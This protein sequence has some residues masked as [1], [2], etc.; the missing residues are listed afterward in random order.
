MTENPEQSSTSIQSKD[1]KLRILAESLAPLLP[2][3]LEAPLFDLFLV[4][5]KNEGLLKKTPR[6]EPKDDQTIAKHCLYTP[7]LDYFIWEANYS[8]TL[9]RGGFGSGDS[10]FLE[11]Y[12]QTSLIYPVGFSITG[13]NNDHRHKYIIPIAT[14]KASINN[15]YSTSYVLDYR[16]STESRSMYMKGIMDVARGNMPAV[17]NLRVRD[18]NFG[19]EK[20]DPYSIWAHYMDGVK[21]PAKALDIVAFASWMISKHLPWDHTNTF[22]RVLIETRSY[23]N[24]MPDDGGKSIVT[25]ATMMEILDGLENRTLI[26]GQIQWQVDITQSGA[27]N[28]LPYHAMDKTD[29]LNP[30]KISI[31]RT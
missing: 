17:G 23:W 8:N 10:A 29:W 20:D 12:K 14:L 7:E 11:A 27:P 22:Q 15:V 4:R 28:T 18:I 26:P 31:A 9:R 2:P 3:L 25:K 21:N 19:F 6:P 13:G 24:N 30:Q 16:V 5:L 1:E